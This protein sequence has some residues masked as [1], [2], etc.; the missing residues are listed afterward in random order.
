V[1]AGGFAVPG[2]HGLS[3]TDVDTRAL[4]RVSTWNVDALHSQLFVSVE[5][6]GFVPLR[7]KFPKFTGRLEVDQADVMRSAFELEVDAQAVATGHAPQEDFIRS[8]PWLDAENHP[9]I[10]FRST[11]IESRGGDRLALRGEL[12]FR[13]VT[14]PVEIPVEFHGVHAD[15]WG[16]RA[17]FTSRFTLHRRD[18]GITWNRTFDWGTMAGEDLEVALDIELSHADP[19]LA[20]QAR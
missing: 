9:T 3:Q 20:V 5:H 12:T 19:S 16:L 8:E 13:G 11:A 2:G 7:A 6:M 18:F 1:D 4:Q 15:G 17:G 10:T 14:R